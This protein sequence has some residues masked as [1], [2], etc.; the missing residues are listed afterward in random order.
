MKGPWEN[1]PYG[2]LG[3][4]RLQYDM[5]SLTEGVSPLSSQLYLIRAYRVKVLDS[6][7]VNGGSAPRC[8]RRDTQARRLNALVRHPG[9][10]SSAARR[11]PLGG[12]REGLPQPRCKRSSAP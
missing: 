5:V 8:S 2:E 12:H 1:T 9:V 3:A 11:R 10:N 6:F 4:P 7:H